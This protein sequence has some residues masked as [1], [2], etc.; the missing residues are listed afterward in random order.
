M[1]ASGFLSGV[2][3]VVAGANFQIKIAVG[4]HKY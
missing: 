1:I 2:H 3:L 4:L